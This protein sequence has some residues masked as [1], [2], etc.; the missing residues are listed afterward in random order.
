MDLPLALGLRSEPEI[1][2]DEHRKAG[3]FR[4]PEQFFQVHR[5]HLPTDVR[6]IVRALYNKMEINDKIDDNLFFN[7]IIHAVAYPVKEKCQNF[8]L[9]QVL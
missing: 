7:I 1:P 4:I 9:T 8:I 6:V 5:K 2:V 3:A